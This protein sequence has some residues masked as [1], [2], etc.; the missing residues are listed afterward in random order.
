MKYFL[1]LLNFVFTLQIF[2]V[3]STANCV[4]KQCACVPEDDLF[5]IINC[6]NAK[7]N[8][9]FQ[10]KGKCERQPQRLCGWTFDKPLIDCLNKANYCKIGGC[11]GELCEID[12]GFYKIGKCDYKPEYECYKKQK[13][14]L[15]ENG[16]CDWA[17]TPALNHCLAYG[18]FKDKAKISDHIC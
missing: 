6:P 7:T 3:K 12:L 15:H 9:C 2:S 5:S 1:T 10:R 11:S 13:C 17:M 4:I 8:L 18:P 14:L 16:S